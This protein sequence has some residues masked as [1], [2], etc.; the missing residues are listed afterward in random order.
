[1]NL[2]AI[3]TSTKNLSLAVS[4]N[5]EI[6]KC[7]NRKLQ[8]PLS[9]S[10]MPG[11]K[12]IL[13]AAGVTLEQLDGFV[14]GL[15]P[16]SFTSLRVGLSTVK[17]LVFAVNKPVV[18]ISSLDALALG[19]KENDVQ[20]C[21]LCDAKRNMAYAC[22]YQKTGTG[23]R[24]IG[25]YALAEVKD[26]LKHIKGKTVFV[27][28]GVK[29]FKDEIRLAR[30]ITPVFM[31]DEGPIPQARYLIPPALQRL[32]NGK[33]DDIDSLVPMYLYPEHCQV[34]R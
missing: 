24:R 2:L 34:R 30:G 28:D 19:V 27:G 10:I 23:L 20:V 32:K 33:Q 6:L 9:S 14:I 22:V 7:R 13:K 29:L 17:G 1:M 18:G 8:R 11:I 31:E 16:G 26:I 15:G 21:A 3:D 25:D 5:A 4:N 12:D